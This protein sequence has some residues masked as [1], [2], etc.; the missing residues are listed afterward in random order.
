MHTKSKRFLSIIVV[1][2]LALIVC[3][4]TPARSNE[5]TI[6]NITDTTSF[7]S[8]DPSGLTFSP[9]SGT[10][11][12]VD[13]EVNETD[14][15]T[16][17]NLF[18]LT[19]SGTV[20]GRY[21][22]LGFSDEPTGITFNT[23][24]GT[25][26][27]TDD[28]QNM[29]FEV[30]PLTPELALS[31][32]STEDFGSYDPEGI[33]FD[34]SNG[35]LFVVEGVNSYGLARSVFEFTPSGALVSSMTLPTEIRDPEG[36]YFDIFTGNLF[37]VSSPDREYIFEVTTSGVIVNVIDIQSLERY[38]PKGIT[39][40][41]SSDPNDCDNIFHLYVANY[42]RDEQM[43]G[44]I[45]E[46]SLE[47]DILKFFDKSVEVGC[48]KGTGRRWYAKFRLCI[49][50]WMLETA[51]YCIEEGRNKAACFTLK[52]AYLRCDGKRRPRD[53]VVGEATEQLAEMIQDL[54][55]SLVR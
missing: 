34:S 18:E 28:D 24:T 8:C 9:D 41:P 42:G 37:I 22:T 7:P 14:F 10:L 15:F 31:E 44:Q 29:V 52:R 23:V 17:Y 45:V 38:N 33:T 54:R 30:D 4:T 43:D 46:I 27:I 25:L 13:S 36:I 26:F 2:V 39:F 49:M 35:N 51:A 48:L 50:R 19:P 40:A 1:M 5:A 12:L 47:T 11:W 32:F 21:S 55:D 53:F 6:V 20:L 3:K 16:G